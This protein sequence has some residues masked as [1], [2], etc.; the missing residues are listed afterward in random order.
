MHKLYLQASIL[1]LCNLI[2]HCKQRFITYIAADFVPKLNN[3]YTSHELDYVRLYTL[4]QCCRR[5]S[6]PALAH[7]KAIEESKHN[8]HA[9]CCFCSVWYSYCSSSQCRL[10]EWL[11]SQLSRSCDTRHDIFHMGF[12]CSAPVSFSVLRS[13]CIGCRLQRRSCIQCAHVDS[14]QIGSVMPMHW[15]CF[16]S[17]DPDTSLS[18]FV[19]S[20]PVR[21]P[22]PREVSMNLDAYGTCILVR[23][24]ILLLRHT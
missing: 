10:L 17:I 6:A 18:T 21:R 13:A 1:L 16:C 7:L 19:Q 15:A 22:L 11:Q 20:L 8:T 9:W 14:A 23:C 5:T 2:P 24:L 3:D 12:H 4:V